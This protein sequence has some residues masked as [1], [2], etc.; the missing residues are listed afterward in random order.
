MTDAL[1]LMLTRAGEVLLRMHPLRWSQDPHL[2]V[3]RPGRPW[4]LREEVGPSETAKRR[5][6]PGLDRV[7]G[8]ETD[9]WR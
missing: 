8:E 1:P 5:S 9:Q 2:P 7:R 4:W 6:S 3:H